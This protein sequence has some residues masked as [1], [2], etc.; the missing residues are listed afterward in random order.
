MQSRRTRSLFLE[1]GTWAVSPL[2]TTVSLVL[3]PTLR[4]QRI[5]RPVP[6][7]C[8]DSDLEAG[9]PV[10]WAQVGEGAGEGVGLELVTNSISGVFTLS[11]TFAPTLEPFTKPGFN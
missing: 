1:A 11:T 5:G 4:E 6:Q 3:P 2:A 8:E 7:A 10:L 9:T